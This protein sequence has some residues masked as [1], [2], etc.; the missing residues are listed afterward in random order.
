MAAEAAY[1]TARRAMKTDDNAT[2]RKLMQALEKEFPLE[3]PA[4]EAG[5]FVGWLDLQAGHFAEA[6][7]AFTDYDQRHRARGA[8]TRRCG[9][10][11]WRTCGSGSTPR[12]A[13]CW[14]RW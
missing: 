4:D 13:R 9:T 6:V 8:G 5:F 1:V 11:R 2:A 12:R 3:A 7:K 10:G 14:T